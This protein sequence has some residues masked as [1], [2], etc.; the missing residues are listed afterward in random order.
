M[1][2]IWHVLENSPT[3]IV[4]GEIRLHINPSA[5][6]IPTL[7]LA[8]LCEVRTEA[9]VGLVQVHVLVNV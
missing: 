7:G 9:L 8:L 3:L 4:R 2:G 6:C 1:S 5:K